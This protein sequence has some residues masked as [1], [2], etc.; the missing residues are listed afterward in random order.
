LGGIITSS[1]P[2]DVASTFQRVFW[3]FRQRFILIAFTAVASK[4]RIVLN[5]LGL[6]YRFSGLGFRGLTH[7]EAL[8]F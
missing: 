1:A 2:H 7:R 6:R 4:G 5:H 8:S 3:K